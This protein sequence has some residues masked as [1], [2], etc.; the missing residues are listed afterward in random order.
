MN[1]I[2]SRHWEYQEQPGPCYGGDSSEENTDKEL[3]GKEWLDRALR[4]GVSG[5]GDV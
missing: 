5:G 1:Q 4:E 2:Y 3:F